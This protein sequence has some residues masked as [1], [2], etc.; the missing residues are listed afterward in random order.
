MAAISWNLLRVDVDWVR[1]G[2]VLGSRL[3]AWSGLPLPWPGADQP[4]GQAGRR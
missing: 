1:V 2:A 3:G 4:D